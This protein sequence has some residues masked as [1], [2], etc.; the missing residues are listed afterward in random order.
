[1]SVKASV[2][3]VISP[4]PL[5]IIGLYVI[6]PSIWL[7]LIISTLVLWSVGV[8]IVIPRSSHVIV[9]IASVI[10]TLIVWSVIIFAVVVHTIIIVII[11]I[12]VAPE[13]GVVVITLT[14]IFLLVIVV[15]LPTSFIITLVFIV[16]E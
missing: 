12:T 1:M 6:N 16:F 8:I 13:I 15:P 11:I 4:S 3:W 2:S 7:G 9:T 14:V 10:V 5:I